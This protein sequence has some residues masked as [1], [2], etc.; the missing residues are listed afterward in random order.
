MR[1]VSA[2]W[3][4]WALG[5]LLTACG[6]SN[7]EDEGP[8]ETGRSFDPGE[9]PGDTD[10]GD[11]TDPPDTD[12]PVDTDS[13]DTDSS[14]DSD[15]DEPVDTEDSDTDEPLDT[16]DTD[17]DTD[18]GDPGLPVDTDTEDSDTDD[19]DTDDTGI[20][21]TGPP[22]ILVEDPP[23]VVVGGQPLP[24][25][26]SASRGTDLSFLWLIDPFDIAATG[27]LTPEVTLAIPNRPGEVTLTLR[28]ED[29]QGRT[30]SQTWTF[31]V[32]PAGDSRPHLF[33]PPF[34]TA[35]N[36]RS[37]H[38]MV[39]RGIQAGDLW[40]TAVART[41][42]GPRD[43]V[44]LD[45]D[46]PGRPA[47]VHDHKAQG[48]G[49]LSSITH[50]FAARDNLLW[51]QTFN[52]AGNHGWVMI[53]VSDPTNPV[54]LEGQNYVTVLQTPDVQGDWVIVPRPFDGVQIVDI[55]DV[56]NHVTLGTWPRP[57]SL[58]I[59]GVAFVG[60][61]RF[62]VHRMTTANLTAYIDLVELDPTGSTTTLGTTAYSAFQGRAQFDPAG[63]VWT[64]DQRGSG[65]IR[66]Y[67]TSGT[68][69]DL[70]W[71][72][73]DYATYP[74]VRPTADRT[75]LRDRTTNRPTLWDTS[76]MPPVL[77]HELPDDA[78]SLRAFLDDRFVAARSTGVIV[79]PLDLLPERLAERWS[80]DSFL[81]NMAGQGDTVWIS[82]PSVGGTDGDLVCVDVSNP[83]AMTPLT[84]RDTPDVYR[85]SAD[86]PF[87]AAPD[88]YRDTVTLFD[89]STPTDP[90]QVWQG[91]P[92]PNACWA[93]SQV[94]GTTLWLLDGCQERLVA[95]DLTTPSAPTVRS[96]T[97]VSYLGWA[98]YLQLSDGYLTL[99]DGWETALWDVRD[100][101][102]PTELAFWPGFDESV[103][104]D[105]FPEDPWVFGN[106]TGAVRRGDVAWQWGFGAQTLDLTDPT[107][108]LPLG[109]T[110]GEG[111]IEE[112]YADGDGL[113][114]AEEE[115]GVSLVDLSDPRR[116]ARVAHYRVNDRANDVRRMG[117]R[118]LATTG[119]AG[120]WSWPRPT[121]PSLA[122]AEVTL[123]VGG[124]T[125]LTLSFTPP[126]DPAY[127]EPEVL[128][129]VADG[130]CEVL[131]VNH[132]AGTAQIRWQLPDTVGEHGLV[133]AVGA[134]DVYVAAWAW[135]F[136]T[137]P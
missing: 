73:T 103:W 78:A 75:V 80:D 1:R 72:T 76:A 39:Y 118:I 67:G 135:A 40:W 83:Q 109:Y 8:D 12:E 31:Q 102:N 27:T 129:E 32:I 96:T 100:P 30:A 54:P 134:P 37:Q 87:L 84:R 47:I 2:V 52:S 122:P 68:A 28:V 38:G 42:N 29:D 131:S 89:L 77:L 44:A 7:L 16:G 49:I 18:T 90:T 56:S 13:G 71:S 125:T 36:T 3:S 35:V 112:A 11:T 10:T 63:R 41:W 132:G 15:T 85:I 5:L 88:Y 51:A 43:L 117:D 105:P 107:D 137:L 115:W 136:T 121:P 127:A 104:V 65:G 23:T 48:P 101:T 21:W 114:L 116:P 19:S 4:A 113:W 119:R 123:P 130:H 60:P 33:L 22:E 86:P 82:S 124:E 91:I 59:T 62:A 111:Y 55:S 6:Q 25:D 110:F 94:E 17:T 97:N 69:P 57:D 50:F 66:V 81:L 133:V 58:Q 9:V 46:A 34:G 64:F 92:V 24:L 74:H 53:D 14:D 45:L 61:N 108:P 106:I 26:A 99:S 126:P 93:D 20:A 128:C 95:L 98:E 79:R 120:L 70:I